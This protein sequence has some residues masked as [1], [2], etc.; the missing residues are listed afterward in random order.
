VFLR[1]DFA[2]ASLRSRSVFFIYSRV[3]QFSKAEE[4]VSREREI[5][6][7]ISNARNERFIT[8]FE[9]VYARKTERFETRT[10]EPREMCR[11]CGTFGVAWRRIKA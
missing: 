1:A 2:F 4:E 7:R 5:I 11:F 3:L 9:R 8:R 10:I 6:A